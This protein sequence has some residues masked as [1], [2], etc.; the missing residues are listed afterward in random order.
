MQQM[1]SCGQPPED[2]VDGQHSLFQVDADGNP[3]LPPALPGLDEPPNCCV[4]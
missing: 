2:L 4:M 1:Q 3:I